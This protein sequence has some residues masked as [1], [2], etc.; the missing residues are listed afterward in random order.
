MYQII[1]TATIRLHQFL[2]ED[3]NFTLF[4]QSIKPVIR[5]GSI[6]SSYT[7]MNN[8]QLLKRK[9]SNRL[10]IIQGFKF[11]ER[12]VGNKSFHVNNGSFTYN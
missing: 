7:I 8:F 4:E 11:Y 5:D 10:N 12:K 6:I 1:I 9:A 2:A 3:Y